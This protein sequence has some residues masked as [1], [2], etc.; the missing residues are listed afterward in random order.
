MLSVNRELYGDLHN[1]GHEFI[2][3]SHDPDYRHLE[4]FGVMG[5]NYDCKNKMC[6]LFLLI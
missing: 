5:T 4:G 2:S 1:M 6:V 3:C